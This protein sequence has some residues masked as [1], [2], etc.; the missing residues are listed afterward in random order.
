MAPREVAE[1]REAWVERERR[2]D[3]RAGVIACLLANAHRDDKA[4]PTPFHVADFFPSLEDLR[5]EPPSDE[6]LERKLVEAL[7]G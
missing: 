5:P 7:G 6:E 2:A 1:L 4:K 3:Y